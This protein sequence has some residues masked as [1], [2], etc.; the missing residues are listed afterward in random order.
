MLKV[1]PIRREEIDAWNIAES[2]LPARVVNSAQSAGIRTIGELRQWSNKDLLRLRSLGR[3]SL[4]HIHSFF[5]LSQQISAGQK[6]FSTFR[7]IL[8]EF[9]DQDEQT[10]LTSRYGFFSQTS[11]ASR[12]YMTLQAISDAEHKTRERIRQVENNAKI[13]LQSKIGMVCLQPFYTYFSSLLMSAGYTV[14]C[15]DII[16]LCD[17]ELLAHYNP[18][19]VLLLLCDLDPER[20]TFMTGFFSTFSRAR[21]DKI[22]SELLSM[23]KESTCPLP[24]EEVARFLP[25]PPDFDSDKS[26]QKTCLT[27]LDHSEHVLISSDHRYCIDDTCINCF[28]IEVMKSLKTPAN[29]RTIT[30]TLNDKLLPRSRKGAGHILETLNAHPQCQRIERGMYSLLPQHR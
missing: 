7:E 28:L 18:C 17:R 25:R 29:F 2:G 1:Q 8:E 19:A 24:S 12:K 5:A 21:L 11:T 6:E 10:V 9:L 22:Q 30:T 26:F 4:K 15:S 14:S 23:L 27:I 16:P 3:I 20:L 13:R